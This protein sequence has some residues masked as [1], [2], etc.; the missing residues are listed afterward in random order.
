MKFLIGL[1]VGAI[2]AAAIGAA[3]IA[4]ASRD[5]D[6]GHFNISSDDDE[7]DDGEKSSRT[8]DLRDFDKIDVRGVFELDVKVGP[9]FAIV[10]SGEADDLDRVEASVEE[11]A[12]ILDQRKRQKGEHRRGH[13]SVK[14][15]VS[16]PSLTAVE[17]SGV[18]DGEIEGVAAAT[19]KVEISGVGDMKI[20]GTCDALEADVSGVGDLDAEGLQCK[21]VE[22]TVSGVGDA[23]VYAS[24][25]VEATV[26]GMGEISVAGSPEKVEKNG[27]MFSNIDV[28]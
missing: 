23:D 25:A 24:E 10:L 5:G 27:G 22:V 14:A 8:L 9:A 12:L 17:A 16:L 13:D 4:Y 2:V 7:D 19:F 18:V 11:G 28:K 1:V 3:A 21:T 6:V 15:T 20:A 26:S